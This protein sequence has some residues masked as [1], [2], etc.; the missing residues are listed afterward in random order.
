MSSATSANLFRWT[1]NPK[2]ALS[3]ETGVRKFD[4]S[5]FVSSHVVNTFLIFTSRFTSSTPATL[6]PAYLHSFPSLRVAIPHFPSLRLFSFPG[7]I[8][9][10]QHPSYTILRSCFP[11]PSSKKV[12]F[13]F[14]HKH[15]PVWDPSQCIFMKY[16]PHTAAAAMSI[17]ANIVML[18]QI[19]LHLRFSLCCCSSQWSLKFTIN[20][21]SHYYHQ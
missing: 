5:F 3:G 7:V 14:H 12:S 2:P 21:T 13:T 8:N 9:S 11:F 6:S 1:L 10:L 18:M 20:E 17:I 19:V 15:H 4:D 16:H